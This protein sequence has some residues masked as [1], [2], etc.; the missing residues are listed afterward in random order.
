M[1]HVRTSNSARNLLK[2]ASHQLLMR[3]PDCSVLGRAKRHSG[4]QVVGKSLEVLQSRAA[5]DG[6]GAISDRGEV[7]RESCLQ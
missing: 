5:T 4:N 6:Y 7:G 1:V 3:H 2:A